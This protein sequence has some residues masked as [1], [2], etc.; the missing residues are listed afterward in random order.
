[1]FAVQNRKGRIEEEMER[2]LLRLPLCFY[3]PGTIYA[4]QENLPTAGPYC[5]MLP[6]AGRRGV[7][8][9]NCDRQILIWRNEVWI[10]TK[11]N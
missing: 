8:E 6:F 7:K 4:V 11:E 2:G 3:R 1:M 9:G 10:R 5:G